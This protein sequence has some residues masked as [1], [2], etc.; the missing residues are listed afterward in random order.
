MRQ[1][2]QTSPI[3][4]RKQACIFKA[5][6]DIRQVSF[7]IIIIVKVWTIHTHYFSSYYYR[8]CWQFKS[9][10]YLNKF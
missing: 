3:H 2:L 7:F 8:I 9:L 10:D 5:G 6:D 4:L 1:L